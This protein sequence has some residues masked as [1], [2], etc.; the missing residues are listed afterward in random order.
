M[1]GGGR[2]IGGVGTSVIAHRDVLVHRGVTHAVVEADLAGDGKGGAVVEGILVHDQAQCPGFSVLRRRRALLDREGDI[3]ARI[4]I[5]STRGFSSLCSERRNHR[6]A[7]NNKNSHALFHGPNEARL[8]YLG[9]SHSMSHNSSPTQCTVL[10]PF[11]FVFSTR[12]GASSTAQPRA[13]GRLWVMSRIHTKS[14]ERT[15]GSAP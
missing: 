7:K 13:S 8:L 5:L 15:D 3:I 10:M 4:D 9:S 14:P 11:P 2:Q 6:Q 12:A 1:V